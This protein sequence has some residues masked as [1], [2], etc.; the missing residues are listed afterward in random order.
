MSYRRWDGVLKF[1][2]MN[3]QTV[4]G[5]SQRVLIAALVVAVGA[6]VTVL[7][8]VAALQRS[9]GQA[10]VAIAGGPGPRADSPE[11]RTLMEALPDQ[12]G[13]YRRAPVVDPAPAGAA[14]WLTDSGGEALILRCGLARPAEFVTGAPIQ[15]VDAVQWFRVGEAAAGRETAADGRS[16]WFAVDRPVYVALTLP[17]GSGPTPIQVLST[18]IAEVLPVRPVDPT[19]AG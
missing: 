19:P 14:G 2:V 3:S 15:M 11:C 7:V 9:P 16:T 13:D 18:T 6:V 8:V 12:L 5:P 17:P 4:D 10:P 1:G